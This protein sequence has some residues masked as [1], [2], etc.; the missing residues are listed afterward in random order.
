VES[1]LKLYYIQDAR[2]YSGNS[3]LWW[4]KEGKGYTTNLADAMKVEADWRGRATDALWACDLVDAYATRQLDMQNLPRINK[5][6][7][8]V[9]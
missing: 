2:S 8:N 9:K 6:A 7:L 5:E 3:V 4:Q 1:K